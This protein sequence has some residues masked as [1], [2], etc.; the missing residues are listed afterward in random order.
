MGARPAGTEARRSAT[1][2][3]LYF[4]RMKTSFKIIPLTRGFQTRVSNQDFERLSAFKWHAGFSGRKTKKV[5]AKRSIRVNGKN[6]FIYMHRFIVGEDALKVDHRDGD[7]LNN[8]RRNLRRASNHQNAC[9]TSLRKHTGTELKG[10]TF[11]RARCKF[12]AQIGVNKRHLFLG[13]FDT[14]EEAHRAYCDAAREHHKAFARF[15]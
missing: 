8:T 12:Q 1:S 13:Y 5:Y 11:V 9:N 4:S 14:K 2:F 6:K 7:G 10:V 15:N 3:G